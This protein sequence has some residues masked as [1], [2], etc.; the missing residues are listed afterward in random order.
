MRVS[1]VEY[2]VF[3]YPK[4]MEGWR[5]FRIEYGGHAESCVCEGHIWLPRGVNPE[6]IERLLS[7]Q[8]GDHV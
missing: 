4:G 8:G 1:L 5:M 3:N 2:G 7:G 6:D